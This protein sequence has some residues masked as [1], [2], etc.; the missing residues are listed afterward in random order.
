[1]RSSGLDTGSKIP[2]VLAASS[3]LPLG[4]SRGNSCLV[5][6][7]FGPLVC[8]TRLSS[9][10]IRL[11]DNPFAMDT[12]V[13]IVEDSFELSDSVV[14]YIDGT[15]GFRCLGAYGSAEQ[16]LSEI[17]RQRPQIVLMDINLPRMSG[18]ECVERLKEVVP[19]IQIVMLTVYEDSDQVFQALAAG[20]CGYLIKSTPPAKLMEA[21]EEVIRGGSPMS[22]HIARKVVQSFKV[23]SRLVLPGETLSQREQEVLEYLSK[24]WPYKQI[25]TSMSISMDTV[26]TY[27]R[28]I[29]E[30]LHVNSRT[31]AVVKYLGT[32]GAQNRSGNSDRFRATV[33]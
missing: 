5:K 13:C 7:E 9:Q 1:M 25:A 29:Y 10:R 11:S 15:P 12:T 22:S 16:A 14:K 21:L 18:I 4:L 8:L 33:Q 20:A 27:I 3:G 31:E 2:E 24:G 23:P 30:K 19:H 17:P 32:T 26:R 6:I 28:R